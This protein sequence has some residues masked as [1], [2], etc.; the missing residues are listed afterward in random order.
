MGFNNKGVEAL[1]SN[2]KKA[3]FQGILG[4]NIG[5]N[6]DTS[7]ANAAEDYLYCLR[8]VYEHASYVTINIS[9]PNTPDL[10]KLQQGDYL[11]QLLSRL[12]EEQLK[13]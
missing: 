7:L 13:L 6:K 9:S 8:T 12:R 10:R 4:I 5:K 3:Y 2:V 11:R 1:V